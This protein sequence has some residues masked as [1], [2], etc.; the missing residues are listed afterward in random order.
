[1]GSGPERALDSGATMGERRRLSSDIK[2]VSGP[3]V[4]CYK[5]LASESTPR[6]L[7]VWL[8]PLIN[9]Q[10]DSVHSYWTLGGVTKPLGSQ[11]I[12]ESICNTPIT[13]STL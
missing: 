12:Y 8:N 4:L 11:I 6:K 10:A 5:L 3:L 7:S 1:M 13:P 9:E 2:P